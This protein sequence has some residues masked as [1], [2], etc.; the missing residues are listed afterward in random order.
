MIDLTMAQKGIVQSHMV[1]VSKTSSEDETEKLR[2]RLI[3]RCPK[4]GCSKEVS[5]NENS[6]YSNPYQHLRS[7]YAK[8]KPQFEQNCVIQELHKSAL[9]EFRKKRGSITSHFQSGNLSEYDRTVRAYLNII[10][11]RVLLLSC[12]EWTEMRS[13]LRYNCAVCRKTISETIFKLVELVENRI[14]LE[15]EETR[16]AVL[17]DGWTV[18]SMHYVALVA[19]YCTKM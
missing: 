10:V 11:M 14:A 16:G 7:C 19:S 3:Y 15:L 5:F 12:V 8:G 6:G 2:N 17:Y 9:E 18:N 4:P 1:F 13:L